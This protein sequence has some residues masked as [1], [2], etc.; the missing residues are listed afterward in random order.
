MDSV[1]AAILKL[2]VA[3]SVLRSVCTSQIYCST[4]RQYTVKKQNI[5]ENWNQNAVETYMHKR[6]FSYADNLT[7]SMS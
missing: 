5:D 1:P 6:N 4:A 7:S 3:S 2:Y